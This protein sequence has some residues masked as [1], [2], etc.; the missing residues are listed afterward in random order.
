MHEKQ[1]PR[2]LYLG[3]PTT[4][5]ASM[6]YVLRSIY[7][8]RATWAN[9]RQPWARVSFYT[10]QMTQHTRKTA[11]LMHRPATNWLGKSRNFE[12]SR[13][14]PITVYILLSL[15]F[16]ER[17]LHREKLGWGGECVECSQKKMKQS[18]VNIQ[19]LAKSFF[20]FLN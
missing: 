18:F 19:I 3:L 7:K 13:T 15:S 20:L 12:I 14:L 5:V 16:P 8:S 2:A 6:V 17:T 4:L 11:A 10:D 9:Q 1:L